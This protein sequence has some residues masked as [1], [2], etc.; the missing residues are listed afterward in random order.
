MALAKYNAILE[1]GSNTLEFWNY[2]AT[3]KPVSFDHNLT[4]N[5]RHKNDST[6]IY[7]YQL[8]SDAY[9]DVTDEET[10]EVV[11]YA[12]I[13]FV[14]NLNKN[15]L[16]LSGDT[17]LDYSEPVFEHVYSLKSNNQTYLYGELNIIETA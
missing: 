13:S 8:P 9:N 11:P 5:V 2:D 3:G 16:A 15:D 1:Y 14:I 17:T 4:F 6:K 10:N 12:M 7:D